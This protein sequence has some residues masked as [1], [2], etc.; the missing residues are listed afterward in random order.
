M[1][2]DSGTVSVPVKSKAHPVRKVA[3]RIASPACGG[4][5]P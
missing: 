1:T 4:I 3:E 2:P 5:I